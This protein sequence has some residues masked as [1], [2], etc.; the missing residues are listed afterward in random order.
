MHT[1]RRKID[2]KAPL[3]APATSFDSI[4]ASI[5]DGGKILLGMASPSLPPVR[6]VPAG[7]ADDGK[8]RLGMAS[9]M[10]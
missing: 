2:M 3:K 9:P 7:T 8:V 4:P 10:I 6:L 1:Q 5:A